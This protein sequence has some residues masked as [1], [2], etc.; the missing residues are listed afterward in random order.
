[1]FVL[2]MEFMFFFYLSF[3]DLCRWEWKSIY[4]SGKVEGT[5]T[6]FHDIYFFS[7][8]AKFHEVKRENVL[9]LF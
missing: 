3:L 8:S 1:M 7:I 4:K 5:C 9:R 2:E 6:N